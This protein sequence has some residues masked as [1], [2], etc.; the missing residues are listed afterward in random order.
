MG[1][2]GKSPRTSLKE[3]DRHERELF[4]NAFYQGDILPKRESEPKNLEEEEDDS[5]LFLRTVNEGLSDL[6]PKDRHV[7]KAP[8]KKR[9][10]KKAAFIDAFVDLHGMTVLVALDV[11][12]QFLGDE[13]TK[14]RRTLLVIH[15]KGSGK[16]KKAVWSFIERHSHVDTIEPAPPRLGGGG[17]IVVRLSRKAR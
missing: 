8:V 3:L 13:W 1:K 14:G 9:L 15:G 11:L 10:A 6:L 7:Q 17:A 2:K 12:R 16:L 4:L 5:A